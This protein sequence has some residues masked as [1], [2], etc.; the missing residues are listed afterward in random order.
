MKGDRLFFLVCDENSQ[1]SHDNN[2]IALN[3]V[4]RGGE[5]QKKIYFPKKRE[6]EHINKE[7]E[8]GGGDDKRVR[9]D[10]SRRME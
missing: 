6:K 8:G 2:P 3:Q 1:K 7:E 9:T 10:R 5:K 4:L